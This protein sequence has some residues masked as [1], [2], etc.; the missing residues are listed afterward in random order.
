MKNYEHV[1]SLFICGHKTA[2]DLN[3]YHNH[4]CYYAI[5]NANFTQSTVI[6][7]NICQDN[8]FVK[9]QIEIKYCNEHESYEGIFS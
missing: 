6:L 8:E 2:A 9:E 1:D 7:N 3:Y 4:P 5:L